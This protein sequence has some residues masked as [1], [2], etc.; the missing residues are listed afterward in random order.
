MKL[1]WVLFA[2]FNIFS[3]FIIMEWLNL[4]VGLTNMFERFTTREDG[5]YEESTRTNVER[6]QEAWE[7]YPP[8]RIGYVMD[9]LAPRMEAASTKE[10]WMRLY[11]LTTHLA[12]RFEKDRRSFDDP[13]IIFSDMEPDDMGAIALL[14]HALGAHYMWIIV[15]EGSEEAIQEKCA[16][17]RFFF[18]GARV[19][20]GIPSDRTFAYTRAKDAPLLPTPPLDVDALLRVLEGGPVIFSLGPPRQLVQLWEERPAAF[21]NSFLKVYGASNFRAV[22]KERPDFDPAEWMRAFSEANLYEGTAFLGNHTSIN[23]E[24]GPA[25]VAF[26]SAEKHPAIKRVLELSVAWNSHIAAKSAAKIEEFMQDPPAAFPEEFV[27]PLSPE[28]EDEIVEFMWKYSREHEVDGAWT[29]AARDFS[30]HRTVTRYDFQM[31]AADFIPILD[32]I[33]M[34]FPDAEF[35]AADPEFSASGCVLH[36]NYGEDS[37]VLILEAAVDHDEEHRRFEEELVGALEYSW[38]DIARHYIDLYESLVVLLEYEERHGAIWKN[39][40]KQLTQAKSHEWERD[41]V[42]MKAQR[43]ASL[44][45]KWVAGDF[46]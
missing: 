29:A 6:M 28:K 22:M 46:D 17:A 33:G 45:A 11:G 14:A 21:K 26:I 30:V 32:M 12:E 44:A 16:D 4:D 37:G 39:L 2:V 31:V 41:R 9:D 10:D 38:I 13:F 24:S 1:W 20:A 25:E 19:F 7:V 3:I 5:F 27:G 23:S 8:W 40:Q 42:I 18:P 43:F 34:F 35:V 36:A 15:G